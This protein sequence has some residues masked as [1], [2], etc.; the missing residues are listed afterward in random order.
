MKAKLREVKPGKPG[1]LSVDLQ[2]GRTLARKWPVAGRKVKTSVIVPGLFKV[3]LP[4]EHRE[5]LRRLKVSDSH[6]KRR[7]SR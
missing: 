2:S 1:I 4:L 7:D 6:H 5:K 3:H